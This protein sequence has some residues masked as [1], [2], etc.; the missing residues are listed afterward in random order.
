M[1]GLKNKKCA[2]VIFSIGAIGYAAIELLWRGRTHW[3]M[4]IAGG[5]SSLGLSKISER[6]KNS[7]LFVK[8]LAGSA[9]ITIVEFI[10]GV[11]FNIILKRKVWDYSRMPLNFRGQICALYSF[12]WLVLSFIFIPIS[13]KI[14]SKMR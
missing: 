8:A 10:F 2:F 7:C 13:D 1:I 9:F 4:M 12:F 14:V 11:L 5:I 6:L 3:S